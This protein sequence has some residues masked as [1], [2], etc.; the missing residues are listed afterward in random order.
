MRIGK[1]QINPS[2][3]FSKPF[4]EFGTMSQQQKVEL[5]DQAT[6]I[7]IDQ[8]KNIFDNDPNL[9]WFI[10]YGSEGKVIKPR[11]NH[12]TPSEKASLRLGQMTGF[13]PFVF[14]RPVTY[15]NISFQQA[16]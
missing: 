4:S 2:S 5:N 15:E 9:R 13:I 14:L 1:E 10:V 11:L 16:A 8:V 6:E 3:P 7:I 12:E